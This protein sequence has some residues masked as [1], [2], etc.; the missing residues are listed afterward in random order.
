MTPHSLTASE[1]ASRLHASLRDYVEAAYHVGDE[2][3]VEQRRRLLD[4]PGVIHQKP[5]LESTPRYQTGQRFA[6]LDIPEPSRRAIEA[7]TTEG[8]DEEGDRLRRRLYDP[9]FTHQ[10]DALVNALR[11][12]RSLVITT[13]TGSGKTESFLLPI[14]GALARQ[15][16]DG[17]PFKAAAVRAILLYPMNALVN[18]QLGRL[19]L[20]LGDPRVRSLFQSWAGRPVRFA[21]Y[22]SRTLY[23]GVRT[24]AKD[25]R[26]LAPLKAFYVDTLRAARNPDAQDHAAKKT[27]YDELR[28]RGKWP[29]KPDLDA[30]WGADGAHWEVNGQPAR[31][32]TLPDDSELLTRHE[33]LDAPPDVLVTNYSMLEYMMLRPVE[34]PIFDKTRQ[35]LAD[36]PGERLLLVIDEAHLYRGASGAEVALL[37][38][39][40]RERLDI[41][42]SRLQ[43]ILTSASF[44]EEKNA[45]TFAADLTG[46]P[47][48]RFDVVKGDLYDR[49]DEG[50]GTTATADLLAG[51]DL[52]AFYSADALVRRAAIAPLLD[53]RGVEAGVIIEGDL[54][55][56]LEAFPPL[57][58][59]VNRSMRGALAIR[60]LG[61]LVFPDAE[62]DVA[63]QAVAALIALGSAAR[64]DPDAPGLLPC[65]VHMFFRGLPGL[66]A[67]L[68]SQCSVLDE[69]LRGGPTG[70]LYAQPQERCR[71]G[72][73]VYELYTC[74]ACG[75]AYARAY[76]DDPERPTYMW[77]EPGEAFSLGDSRVESLAP[78]DLLLELPGDDAQLER[79]EVDLV[80]GR[81]NVRGASRTRRAWLT[82]DRAPR[83]AADGNRP[84]TEPGQYEEC[85]VCEGTASFGRSP[86]QDHQTKGDQPFQALVTE[87]VEVQ[88]PSTRK[89]TE[90]APLQGRKTL[91]FSDSRQLAARMAPVVQTLSTRDALRPLLV[92]G[93]DLIARHADVY[94]RASLGDAYSA[95]L[96]A[97][98]H[99]GVHLRPAQ[100]SRELFHSPEIEAAVANGVLDDPDELDDLLREDRRPP[101]SL[102][103]DLSDALVHRYYGLRPLGL[104]TVRERDRYTGKL[105]DLPSLPGLAESDEQ[106][107]AVARLW[108][109]QWLP[110]SLHLSIL[111]AAA[112]DPTPA[113]GM[114]RALG[115][116][117]GDHKTAFEQ[118]WKG[119][120]IDL[121]AEQ[122]TRGKHWLRGG[123]L[124]LDTGGSG[125]TAT[126]AEPRSGP[127]RS[128]AGA[129]SVASK[130]PFAPW[131]RTRTLS[132]S[133]GKA[134]T[135]QRRQPLAKIRPEPPSLF[136]PPS[137]P[138]NSTLYA[139]ERSTPKRS[140]TNSYSKTL[141]SDPMIRDVAATPWTSCRARRRWRWAS[142]SARS[143]ASPFATCLR[144]VPT[145][146]SARAE[147]VAAATPSRP[148][149]PS[150]APTVT[151]STTSRSP[152]R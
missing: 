140:A 21:R 14:L 24:K 143:Q 117:L 2:R 88:P 70:T 129:S 53:H 89:A 95:V 103:K 130:T 135:A 137:T 67:C 61:P 37:L 118:T 42:E 15:A 3:L 146:S 32:V 106:K 43:V 111:D 123:H 126:G 82:P 48:H 72:A 148:W 30:W 87:Q 44:G 131:T 59:L 4:V 40:L 66:W 33:V 36:H 84:P 120:L 68:D 6:E 85:A 104:A 144:R 127:S 152:L 60:E 50:S 1:T 35:W 141:T 5:Y 102:A 17:D 10:A 18:D 134:T 97:A 107:V 122:T 139:M 76:V 62:P 125:R 113:T 41:D 128:P 49:P 121:F 47:A 23:P 29:A 78:L 99:L 7:V 39:R 55:R 90:F 25:Q 31:C 92:V 86:V 101:Q 149:S 132:S 16:A 142:T 11:D 73:R 83:P 22:T 115:K 133:P 77:S 119:P 109:Q 147:P 151:T 112:Q 8:V 26:R 46:L 58:L 34:R 56:A 98:A 63:E 45:E 80:T 110:D 93:Y 20:L 145:T 105:L 136:S 100:T 51:L 27:L 57:S 96:L 74:R 12:G 81:L 79:V 13:G 124:T 69:D 9:P 71:C 28:R 138:P 150:V 38:R 65:R 114:T 54:Y 19:R 64:I 75:T 116:W 52:D 94:R 108:L 91:I